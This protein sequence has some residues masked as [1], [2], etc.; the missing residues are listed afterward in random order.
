MTKD[1][2]SVQYCMPTDSPHL[3]KK[4]K[5]LAVAMSP[6]LWTRFKPDRFDSYS[7]GMRAFLTHQD[8]VQ[9]H[10]S[11]Q[12][13]SQLCR[14]QL[15]KLKT[16]FCPHP[17]SPGSFKFSGLHLEFLGIM[18]RT[19]VQIP[20]SSHSQHSWNQSFHACFDWANSLLLK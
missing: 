1:C 12:H 8:S 7:C 9:W 11:R 20:K 15:F 5:P 10:R 19:A 6:M 18:G 2:L 13:T 17:Y 16:Y 3:S 4:L 14:K